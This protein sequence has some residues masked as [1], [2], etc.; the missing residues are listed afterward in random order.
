MA[1][2]SSYLKQNPLTGYLK[3]PQVPPPQTPGKPQSEPLRPLS[4]YY[5]APQV[6]PVQ[7]VSQP[8]GPRQDVPAY[9]G[10]NYAE[11]HP[12]T[13]YM[14]SKSFLERH[15]ALQ[16]IDA[17]K[18]QKMYTGTGNP[19][20][21]DTVAVKERRLAEYFPSIN[22]SKDDL[23]KY[24]TNWASSDPAR[25]NTVMKLATDIK[26]FYDGN[27][28][29]K[30]QRYPRSWGRAINETVNPFSKHIDDMYE[31]AACVVKLGNNNLL[32]GAW[33]KGK[34]NEAQGVMLGA[35]NNVNSA[36]PNLA[37]YDGKSLLD[38]MHNIKNSY[39]KELEYNKSLPNDQGAYEAK[40]A[41]EK[42]L[43]AYERVYKQC[44]ERYNT[45]YR[46]NDINNVTLFLQAYLSNP[47][48]PMDANER[49]VISEY[50]MQLGECKTAK[51]AI[52]ALLSSQAMFDMYA[53]GGKRG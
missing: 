13:G 41:S 22:M 2:N 16:A 50:I 30:K 17:T 37:G 11:Q 46:T 51:D 7:P 10:T 25:F 38:F 29:I 48:E 32:N 20:T 26:A 52:N 27:P 6:P 36:A 4:E 28:Q 8:A 31:F 12:S 49:A 19:D 43:D 39:A 1:P 42:R 45:Y 35:Y 33:N 47:L 9:N 14:Q 18:K 21:Q 53:I 40:A 44:M 15:P 24:L 5:T 3:E 34:E 23:N